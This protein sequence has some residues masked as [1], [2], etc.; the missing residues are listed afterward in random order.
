MELARLG[1]RIFVESTETE[2]KSHALIHQ[3]NLTKT[4]KNLLKGKT[5][6]TDTVSEIY[7]IRFTKHLSFTAYNGNP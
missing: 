3:V 4:P 7:K 2:S 1:P 5:A 6:L